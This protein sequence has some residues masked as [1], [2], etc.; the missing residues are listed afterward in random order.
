ME[1]SVSDETRNN[2]ED[3]VEEQT[4]SY[5]HGVQLAIIIASLATSVFLVAL[6]ETI[7]TTAVPRIS[8]EFHAM[9]DIGWYGSA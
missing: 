5:P 6:D 1:G 2:K 8:D 7:I 9:N 3:A 4:P